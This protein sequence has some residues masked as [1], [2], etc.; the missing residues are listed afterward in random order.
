MTAQVRTTAA[1]RAGALAE[2]AT[3]RA[4]SVQ[5]TALS[6]TRITYFPTGLR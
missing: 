4:P 2:S 1:I 5:Q 3:L 6:Q